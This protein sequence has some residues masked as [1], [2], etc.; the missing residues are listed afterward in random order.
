MWHSII[1]SVKQDFFGV[2]AGA[3]GSPI[4]FPH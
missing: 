4:F 3:H 1:G 2:E